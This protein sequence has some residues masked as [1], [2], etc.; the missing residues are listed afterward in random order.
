MLFKALILA[1]SAIAGIS[2]EIC[3]DEEKRSMNGYDESKAAQEALI[4]ITDDLWHLFYFT[5]AGSHGFPRY[6]T[7][8]F[9]P[10]SVVAMDFT[11]LYCSGDSFTIYTEGPL[12]YF[13]VDNSS[14]PT[15][16]SCD[17]YTTDPATAFFALTPWARRIV[18]LPPIVG[19]YN[20]TI[21]MRESPYSAGAMAL[22]R[23]IT[24][25]L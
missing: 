3:P 11:D 18:I 25:T 13:S 15:S 4:P 1:C 14:N 19:T 2:A 22:R 10:S 8:I 24:P 5:N 17:P 23:V 16:V 20:F 7:T 21:V 6:Q 12:G 9:S